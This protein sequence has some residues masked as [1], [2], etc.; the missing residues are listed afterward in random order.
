MPELPEVE[1]TLRGVR[2]YLEGRR[3]AKRDWDVTP[4]LR[5]VWEVV[6]AQERPR[7]TDR[8]REVPRPVV[9]WQPPTPPK[10]KP[11]HMAITL[12]LLITIVFLMFRLLPGDPLAMYVNTD[13]PLEVQKALLS[14]FGL[15]K[16]LHEQY[17][18]YFVG[19][20]YN[21]KL[22]TNQ[23][24]TNGNGTFQSRFQNRF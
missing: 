23:F 14:R 13:M 4:G 20:Q 17:F 24:G 10:E 18:L 2:P 12:F 1:T 15:D 8:P 6:E 7:E 9:I 22:E 11:L 21:R 16:P 5:K 3:I 19:F